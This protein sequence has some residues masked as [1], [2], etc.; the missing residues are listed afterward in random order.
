MDDCGF[1]F[2]LDQPSTKNMNE[3]YAL[4][5]AKFDPTTPNYIELLSGEN[6]ED[7]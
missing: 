6:A 4:E 5:S 2:C 3:A 1:Q 7:Y